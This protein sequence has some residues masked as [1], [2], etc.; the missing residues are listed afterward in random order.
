MRIRDWEIRR[1]GGKLE[2][3]AEVDGF[4][5]WYGVPD[6]YPVARSADPFV[7]AALLPAMVRGEKLEVDPALTVSP[8]L[9]RNA[10][11]LQEI[12]HAWNPALK[13]VPITART[14][15]AEELSDGTLSFFS[16]GVDS[17]YTFLKHEEEISHLVLIHGFDFYDVSE[18]YRVAVER[19][20]RFAEAHGKTLI[21]IETNYYPFGYRYAMSRNLTQG[22][23]LGA[24]ALLLGFATAYV[25]SSL[26]YDELMPLGS[27]PL[28]DPLW[29]N[30]AVQVIHDG[31]EAR[32]TDK[33]RKILTSDAA[34]ANLRVCFEDMNVNCGQCAKCLRTMVALRFLGAAGAPFP[35][36]PRLDTIVKAA[37]GHESE[38]MALKENLALPVLDRDSQT[39]ALRDRLGRALRRAELRR[40]VRD[41]DRALLGGR[42]RRLL[43]RKQPVVSIGYTLDD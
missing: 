33:L 34:L 1:Q 14:V 17:T 36:L 8:R 18:S 10:L 35:P 28:T 43:V 19:N 15:R 25:P 9:L 12:F 6:A 20:S 42:M 23:A 5:L 11:H 26:A 2:V 21:P 30:E 27:H 13:I 40:A 29:S 31:C 3:V 38:R 41:M 22:S 37:L 39:A 7:A 32:R 24:V 4:R 16:G